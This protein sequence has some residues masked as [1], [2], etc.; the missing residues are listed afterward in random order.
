[1]VG[2]E[3]LVK[4]F[5]ISVEMHYM[6]SGVELNADRYCISA[7]FITGKSCCFDLCIDAHVQSSV[8][9]TTDKSKIFCPM[10]VK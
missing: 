7:A 9:V 3:Q 2:K 6:Q 1:M 5:T 8:M 4:A 10:H